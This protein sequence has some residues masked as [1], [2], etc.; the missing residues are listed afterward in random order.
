MT[1]NE[2][3]GVSNLQPDECLLNRL[4]KAQIIE[5]IKALLHWPLGGKFTG[6]FP[7]QMAS[8]VENVSIWWRHNFASSSSIFRAQIYSVK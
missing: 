4:F 1:H 7:A 5:N 3:D 8:N 2:R 6:D